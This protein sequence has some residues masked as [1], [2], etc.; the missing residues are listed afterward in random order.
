MDIK[1]CTDPEGYMHEPTNEPT[2]RDPEGYMHGHK[3]RPLQT[4]PR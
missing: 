3:K 2:R 1:I 4:A